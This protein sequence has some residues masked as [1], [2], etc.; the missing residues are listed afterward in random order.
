[1]SLD[2]TRPSV[3]GKLD[4]GLALLGQFTRAA[5]PEISDGAIDQYA[6]NLI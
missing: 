1:M 2:A 3:I 5:R 4:K 6:G